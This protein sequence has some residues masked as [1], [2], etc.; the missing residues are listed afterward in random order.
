MSKKFLVLLMISFCLP[1]S[2]FALNV[3]NLDINGF[4]SQGY[5][6][7]SD[8]NFL[9]ESLDGTFQFNEAGLTVS[10]QVS[11]ELRI[12]AQMLARDL[13]DVGNNDITLDW[14]YGDYKQSDV[15]G[16]RLGKVKMPM[17]FY[18]ETRDSDF[19]RPMVFLPQSIYKEGNRDLFVAYQGGGF[20]GNLTLGASGDLE[21]HLFGGQVNI[22]EDSDMLRE[23]FHVAEMHNM[24][25]FGMMPAM[26]NPVIA[27]DLDNDYVYGGALVYSTP[28]DGLRLGASYFDL[29]SDLAVTR[30]DGTVSEGEAN[31]GDRFVASIEYANPYFSFSS[32]YSEYEFE[33]FFFGQ[34]VPNGTSQAWYAML[35]YFITEKLS[36]SILYDEYYHDKDD[37]DGTK[38]VTMVYGMNM[39]DFEGWRKDLGIGLRFNV[40]RNFSIK[41]EYHDIEGVFPS[42]LL[43]NSLADLAE[44]W[45]YYTFKASF[46]F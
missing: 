41:A 20:Y 21:Y 24:L 16:V 19:M 40:N 17:G 11:D 14:G 37:K 32:E 23:L 9:S 8:N 30:S 28:L 43:H 1:V 34:E 12:G 29:K 7:S 18:N 5:L 46:N 36:A 35:T 25:V 2:A 33:Q 27:V 4:V 38:W 10:A 3:Q 13:G 45:D 15:F 44:E 26:M 6:K 22:P 42:D 31:M 39:R